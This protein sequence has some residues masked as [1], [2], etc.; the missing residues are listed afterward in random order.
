MKNIN[1]NVD[2]VNKLYTSWKTPRPQPKLNY[3]DTALLIID[4]QYECASVEYGIF[5]RIKN[6]ENIL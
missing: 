4:M 2:N 3:N 5:K 6:I 1:I